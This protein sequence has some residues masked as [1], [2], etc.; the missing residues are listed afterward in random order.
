MRFRRLDFSFFCFPLLPERAIFEHD[1]GEESYE[2]ASRVVTRGSGQ[3]FATVQRK[4]H[5]I[6]PC[7]RRSHLIY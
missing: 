4:K 5:T 6:V 2:F 7:P 3:T 1:L